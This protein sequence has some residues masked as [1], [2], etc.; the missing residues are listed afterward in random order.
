MYI[1]YHQS[2]LVYI[3]ISSAATPKTSLVSLDGE[4]STAEFRGVVYDGPSDKQSAP[5]RGSRRVPVPKSRLIPYSQLT[6]GPVDKVTIDRL[7]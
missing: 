6:H 3:L 1:R 7:T 4:Q 2:G 5:S